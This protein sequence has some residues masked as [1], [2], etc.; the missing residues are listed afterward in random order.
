MI[1]MLSKAETTSAAITML[2]KTVELCAPALKERSDQA[3]LN[4]LRVALLKVQ[5]IA[6]T[7]PLTC[8]PDY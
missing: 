5:R 4:E 6:T 7:S 1:A 3:K 2:G 8:T